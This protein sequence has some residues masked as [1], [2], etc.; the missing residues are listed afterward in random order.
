MLAAI[1]QVKVKI[2]LV[3]CANCSESHLCIQRYAKKLVH[4]MKITANKDYQINGVNVEFSF[5][6]LPNEVVGIYERIVKFCLLFLFI[7]QCV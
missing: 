3:A 2:F 6:L 4:D 1:L 5:E 7:W